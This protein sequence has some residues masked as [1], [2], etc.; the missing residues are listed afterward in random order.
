MSLGLTV[1]ALDLPLTAKEGNSGELLCDA[2]LRCQLPSVHLLLFMLH[3]RAL[4]PPLLTTLRYL[5]GAFC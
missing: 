4:L 2:S 5:G 3:I 1:N